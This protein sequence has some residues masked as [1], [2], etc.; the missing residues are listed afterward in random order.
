MAKSS[1]N[2]TKKPAASK[3]TVSKKKV[4]KKTAVKKTAAKKPA[5]SKKTTT[6]KVTKPR[7]KKVAVKSDITPEERNEM[8]AVAAYYRWEQSG[9]AA[10]LEEEHW[11]LAE[12]EIENLLNKSS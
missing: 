5:A 9:Y 11:L 8:I 3:K 2:S 7:K 6:A 10:E 12:E 1:T 4:A